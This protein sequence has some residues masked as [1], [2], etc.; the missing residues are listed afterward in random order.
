MKQYF[1]SPRSLKYTLRVCNC[2]YAKDRVLTKE[3]QDIENVRS[4]RNIYE[5]IQYQIM[6]SKRYEISWEIHEIF[7]SDPPDILIA[8]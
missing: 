7:I 6:V 8:C 5:I 4:E 1:G 3:V 2:S